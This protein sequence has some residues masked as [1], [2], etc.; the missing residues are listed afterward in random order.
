MI[1][2]VNKAKLGL[3]RSLEVLL[4]LNI[5]I[6]TK[7]EKVEFVI[8]E[9]ERLYPNTPIPLNHRNKFELLIAVLLSAQCT[10][11]RVNKVTPLLFQKANNPFNMSKLTEKTIYKRT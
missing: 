11:E 4:K 2:K 10:D 1:S 8:N 6:L 3:F 9:L 5:C 7:A